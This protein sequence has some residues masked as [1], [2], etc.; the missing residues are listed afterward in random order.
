MC[1]CVCVCLCLCIVLKCACH[2][3]CVAC[4]FRL[5]MYLMGVMLVAHRYF[6]QS[7]LL[8]SDWQL[9]SY[10]EEVQDHTV[11][12]GAKFEFVCKMS[13]NASTGI[14]DP[15]VLRVSIRKVSDACIGLRTTDN[16]II[17]DLFLLLHCWLYPQNRVL[18]VLWHWRSKHR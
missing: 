10:R 3:K 16:F 17:Q 18:V 1:V 4:F 9:L 15:C 8:R 7:T 12:W 14:L 2:E 11:R 5:C 6:S 13:A